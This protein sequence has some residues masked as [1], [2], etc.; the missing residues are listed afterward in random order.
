MIPSYDELTLIEGL[1]MPHAWDVLDRDRG[2][3]S[4]LSSDTVRSAATLVSE[5]DVIPLNLSLGEIDPPLFGRAPYKHTVLP[6]SRNSNE[7]KL[8]EF[9]PQSTS[10]WDGLRHVRAKQH[11]FFGGVTEIAADDTETLSI[12]H[13][14][15]SGIVGRGVLLDVSRYLAST[16]RPLDPFAGDEILAESLDATAQ[17]QGV[18]LHPGD[19]ACVRTGWVDAYRKLDTRGRRAPELSQRFSGLRADAATAR[20]FWD[21]HVAALCADNPAVEVAPGDKSVGYLHWR[22]LPTLGLAVAELLDLDTLAERCATLRR[23]EFL[24]VAVPL[25]VPGGVS[26]PS[27]AVAIL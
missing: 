10:Q 22:L 19:I 13:W 25:P 11:G 20:F 15:R 24:F 4:L 27:N 2:T 21:N 14:A 3:V 7:D 17:A 9:N 8:D 23:W 12:E 6:V 1:G 5:G 16:G 26:S 18:E